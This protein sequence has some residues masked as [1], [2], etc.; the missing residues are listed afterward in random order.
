MCST[1]DSRDLRIERRK[2]KTGLEL[3]W[4]VA[5]L[6]TYTP[7]GVGLGSTDRSM[8]WDGMGWHGAS[9]GM[10]RVGRHLL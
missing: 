6:P 9:R 10:S 1:A 3:W 8:G 4:G 2:R 5:T 7:L